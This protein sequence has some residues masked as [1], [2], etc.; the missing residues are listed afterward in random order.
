[1]VTTLIDLAGKRFGNLTVVRRSGTINGQAA[2]LCICDCGREKVIR[3]STLRNGQSTS[4][5]CA[6]AKLASDRLKTHG[7][8]KTRLFKIWSMMKE[9]CY[10]D[11]SKSYQGY[12]GRGIRVC[13]EWKNSFTSF[14]GW[15]MVNGYT[16]ELTIDRI[17][18]NG[19]YCPD[20]CR[21]ATVKEQ[22]NNRR[23]N[24]FLSVGGVSKTAAEWSLQS[25][26]KQDTI[27]HRI[28]FGW[29]AEDA[30]SI[31]VSGGGKL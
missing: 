31:P 2:W 8:T 12:G 7:L 16:D 11:Y 5:G 26:I 10:K 25:G 4:C 23:S 24:T 22:A 17:D 29:S 30:V 19:N 15:A 14:F 18:V 20:N 21:W 1:M 13:D 28:K 6:A 27:L 3:G 9:R